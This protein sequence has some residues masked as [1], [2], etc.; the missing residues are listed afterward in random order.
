MKRS[1]V[2][3]GG[4][5]KIGWASGVLQVLMDEAGLS[6]DHIDATSGS[7]FNLAML[8]SGRS[9]TSIAE[10]AWGDLSAR[11]FVSLHP[12]WRYVTFWR[13]PSLLTQ[14]AAVRHVI[15]K[16]G[17]DLERIRACT[18]LNGHPVVATFNV[19]D[20]DAKRVV[21]F[22]NTEMDLD[23]LLA[24]DAVPGV[25]PPV[26]KDGTLYVD[27]MLLEDA[28][29]A[30][31]VRQG[32]DEI[33]IVWTVEERSEWRG[34]FWNHLGHVFEVCAVGNLKRELDAI[35][36]MNDRVAAGRGAPGEKHVTVHLLRPDHRLPVSYLFFRSKKQMRA[37]IELGRLAARRYLAEL[38]TS[39]VAGE[40]APPVRA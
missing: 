27:A 12:P 38:E 2:L 24:I 39:G 3:A 22:R 33:W 21:T 30:E 11:E 6:F 36:A 4:G 7:V 8:L 25:V 19:C 16:W 1:L 13:L 10:D 5:A 40:P 15:P 32:A 23:R 29:V 18:E 37:T 34:G 35:D 31:A 9:A 17:I 26:P 20:F 14:D 28:N